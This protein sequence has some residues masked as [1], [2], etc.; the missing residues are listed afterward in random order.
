MS[1]LST[2]NEI[3]SN[4]QNVWTTLYAG[5]F[6]FGTPQEI[7]N[8]H[9]KT[10]PLLFV[11][12]PQTRFET[13][14][15]QSSQWLAKTEW[16]VVIYNNLPSTYNVTDDLAVAGLWDTMEN[17]LLVWYESVYNTFETQGKIMNVTSPLTVT[18]LKESSND[19][20]LGLKAT[21]GWDYYRRCLTL[22]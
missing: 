11:Y 10:L 14:D 20:L 16:T 17:Q 9:N 18:R 21:F 5:G 13:N 19:R 7:D 4:M 2:T 1:N 3:L 22:N 12:T 8:I 6:H 15:I